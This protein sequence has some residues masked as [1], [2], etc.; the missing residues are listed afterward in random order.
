M[1]VHLRLKVSRSSGAN[2]TVKGSWYTF[3][4]NGAAKG[5]SFSG[6]LFAATGRLALKFTFPKEIVD[7]GRIDGTFQPSTGFMQM[8]LWVPVDA[9]GRKLAL[10]TYDCENKEIKKDLETV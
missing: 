3:D 8:K 2:W 10:L 5:H 9:K 6:T 4:K 1:E 7:K